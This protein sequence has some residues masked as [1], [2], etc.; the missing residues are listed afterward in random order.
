MVKGMNMPQRFTLKL[1]PLVLLVNY[2]LPDHYCFAL[3]DQRSE[4]FRLSWSFNRSRLECAY[5]AK[6]SAVRTGNLH[7]VN[8]TFQNLLSSKQLPQ[9]A[10]HPR[11]KLCFGMQMQCA[12]T[13]MYLIVAV[14]MNL[15]QSMTST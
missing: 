1:A 15:L 12:L 11:A 13:R 4:N 6:V 10:L 9:S 3:R 5:R 2:L 8:L 7:G 14:G